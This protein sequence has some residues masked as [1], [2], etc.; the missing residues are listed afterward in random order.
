MVETTEDQRA[1]ILANWFPRNEIVSETDK[2]RMFD[3]AV[4]LGYEPES[5]TG[6]WKLLDEP[7]QFRNGKVIAHE[8]VLDV[9]NKPILDGNTLKTRYLAH[10]LP[11]G[12]S[13]IDDR[14]LFDAR[15]HYT[16]V[17]PRE[18]AL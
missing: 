5:W 15:G 17:S 6:M 10:K 13:V 16:F 11:A 1:R 3:L 2:G 7:F 14:R 9:D 18:R 4:D 8:V 12:W